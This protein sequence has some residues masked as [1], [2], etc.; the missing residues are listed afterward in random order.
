[1]EIESKIYKNLTASLEKN[2]TKISPQKY[3]LPSN[4]I[5]ES[6]SATKNYLIDHSLSHKQKSQTT[7]FTHK[8]SMSSLFT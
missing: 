2:K 5:K 3:I 7:L 4:P 6:K 8:K 1:M